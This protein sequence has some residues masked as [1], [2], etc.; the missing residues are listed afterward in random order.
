MNVTNRIMS[1]SEAKAEGFAL[2]L[3]SEILMN[4]CD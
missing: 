2:G 1:P 3:G 4:L